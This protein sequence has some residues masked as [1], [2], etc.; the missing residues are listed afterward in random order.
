MELM[1]DKNPRKVQAVVNAMMTMDKL[2]VPT[3]E[4]AYDAA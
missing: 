4:K 2:D 1:A 3:L